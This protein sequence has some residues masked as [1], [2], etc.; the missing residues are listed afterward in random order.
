MAMSQS[1]AISSSANPLDMVEEVITAHEWRFNRQGDDELMVGLG[2]GFCDFQMWFSWREDVGALHLSCGFDLK[3]AP[4]KR[5]ETH[6]LLALLNEKLAVGHFDLWTDEG[7]VVFRHAL[8][9][10]GGA[11]VNGDQVETLV[12]I[13][14]TECER[15]YPAFQFMLWGGKS[16]EDALVAALIETVGEA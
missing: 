10:S 4:A 12:Q 15:F 9:L 3:V 13:A 8:L 14:L 11:G 6:T 5:R 7:L 2:G 16:P 1:H